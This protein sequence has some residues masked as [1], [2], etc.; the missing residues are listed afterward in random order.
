MP[1]LSLLSTLNAE[2]RPARSLFGLGMPSG[3]AT[4]RL[5]ASLPWAFDDTVGHA[6]FSVD[7]IRRLAA[8]QAAGASEAQL[9][10]HSRLWRRLGSHE[11]VSVVAIGGS[12]MA[13]MGCTSHDYNFVDPKTIA[14][15]AFASR[16]IRWMRDVMCIPD[17]QLTYSNRAAGGCDTAG[18]LPQLPLLLDVGGASPDLL[19]IDFSAN[20]WVNEAL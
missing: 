15:C 16:F 18:A 20:D 5:N 11:P 19:I 8:E 17:S 6:V 4:T 14:E 9:R 7:S 12:M 2:G 1:A 13:G 10:A 3:C